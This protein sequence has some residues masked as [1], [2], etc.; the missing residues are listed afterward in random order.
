M[1]YLSTTIQPLVPY[2]KSREKVERKNWE[3]SQELTSTKRKHFPTELQRWFRSSITKK[4]Y[5]THNC[6]GSCVPGKWIT[7]HQKPIPITWNQGW[8]TWIFLASLVNREKWNEINLTVSYVMW[9]PNMGTPKQKNLANFGIKL[10]S[11]C[12]RHQSY[13]NCQYKGSWTGVNNW[14]TSN[15]WC[16]NWKR[17]NSKR[18]LQNLIVWT[19][20]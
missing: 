20:F 18:T 4:K 7:Q 19:I 14:E 12:S 9:I 13:L 15:V 8:I 17:H 16:G 5:P 2:H 6:P 11:S 10:V 3:G 1:P